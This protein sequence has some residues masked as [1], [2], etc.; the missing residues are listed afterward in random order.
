MTVTTQFVYNKVALWKCLCKW[1]F[2]FFVNGILQF[3]LLALLFWEYSHKGSDYWHSFF[4]VWQHTG[5]P[6]PSLC[7]L[8]K[9]GPR[10]MSAF[11]GYFVSVLSVRP[12]VAEWC[13]RGQSHDSATVG[14][15]GLSL[16]LGGFAFAVYRCGRRQ[17]RTLMSHTFS[18]ISYSYVLTH[19]FIISILQTM[20]RVR[21]TRSTILYFWAYF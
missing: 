2:F 15:C 19:F 20:L 1:P 7:L 13:C 5:R 9:E 6:F 14:H 21:P 10:L 16:S 11:P 12:T 17:N 8:D 18:H 3:H 4:C